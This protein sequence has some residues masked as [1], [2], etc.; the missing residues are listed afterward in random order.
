MP[1]ID[2]YAT[3]NDLIAVLT[4]AFE[5]SGCRVFESY[6]PFGEELAEFKSIGDIS[7]RYQMGRCR[8]AAHSVLLQLIPP[9]ASNQFKVERID[10]DPAKYEGHAFRYAIQGWGLIQLY[11]GGTGLE[12]LVESHSNHNSEAR[13]KKW[14]DTYPDLGP[15]EA[16]NWRETTAVSSALNRYIRNLATYKLGSR[17]V[18]PDAAAAFASGVS[19]RDTAYKKLLSERRLHS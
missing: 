12:G 18:L 13:S 16:W 5:R 1:N 4:Y 2:F 17:P 15:P 11:L 8:G 3:A 9:S 7:A 14:A 10:L 6:S 19:P